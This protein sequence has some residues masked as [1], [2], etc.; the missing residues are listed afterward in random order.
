MAAEAAAAA[1]HGEAFDAGAEIMHHILDAPVWQLHLGALDM[2]ITRAV[3]M[4]WV[5]SAVLLVV[6]GIAARRAKDPV[7]GGLRNLLEILI[8]AIRDDVARKN[9]G[10]GADRYVG[11]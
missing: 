2:T 4:M 7:P 1:E 6:F 11:Y 5:A 8:L 10:H 9:I 3:I